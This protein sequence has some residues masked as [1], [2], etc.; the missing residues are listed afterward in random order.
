MQITNGG[1]ILLMRC[2]VHLINK[3]ARE[4]KYEVL[5]FLTI[6]E[7][8][9]RLLHESLPEGFAMITAIMTFWR[10]RLSM[11]D[12]DNEVQQAG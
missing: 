8:R 5:V 12:P 6:P 10:K 4:S 1:S 7:K 11:E 3:I 2:T 9:R